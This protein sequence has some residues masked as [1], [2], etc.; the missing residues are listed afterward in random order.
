MRD[1]EV[2]FRLGKLL[3]STA[4]FTAPTDNQALYKDEAGIAQ[5]V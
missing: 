5:S 4:F 3:V 2:A 1:Q